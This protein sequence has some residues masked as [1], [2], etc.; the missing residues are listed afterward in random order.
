M[1]SPCCREGGQPVA[2]AAQDLP[3][4]SRHPRI[5]TDLTVSAYVAMRTLADILGEDV[6]SVQVID[7]LAFGIIVAGIGKTR[8]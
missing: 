2:W 8:A 5:L 4:K 7:H 3:E 6:P 1:T